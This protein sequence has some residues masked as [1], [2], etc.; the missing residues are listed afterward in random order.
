MTVTKGPAA[1][2][3]YISG[4]EDDGPEL[5]DDPNGPY[6]AVQMMQSLWLVSL[7][8]FIHL[9]VSFQAGW[10]IHAFFSW[11][12]WGSTSS[13]S[14][15]DYFFLHVDQFV[16]VL[17]F[18]GSE[19]AVI[20]RLWLCWVVTSWASNAWNAIQNVTPIWHEHIFWSFQLYLYF[21]FFFHVKRWSGKICKVYSSMQK[22]KSLLD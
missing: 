15:S 21:F 9:K 1:C 10:T 11:S 19:P 8:H 3:L 7:L 22:F 20:S 16:S 2:R 13:F 17:H 18:D 12:Y 5:S 4:T 6:I 14:S